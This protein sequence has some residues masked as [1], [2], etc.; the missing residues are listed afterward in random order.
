MQFVY[1]EKLEEGGSYYYSCQLCDVRHA[2]DEKI[3]NHL[4]GTRH[5]KKY[6]VSILNVHYLLIIDEFMEYN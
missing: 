5:N 2:S 1:K 4:T 6:L 3:Y